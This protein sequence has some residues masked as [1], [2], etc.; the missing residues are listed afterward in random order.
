LCKRWIDSGRWKESDSDERAPGA[1]Q[2]HMHIA[3]DCT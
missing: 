1:A 2:A 3:L